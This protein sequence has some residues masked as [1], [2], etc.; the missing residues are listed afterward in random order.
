MNF[1]IRC[2]LA[3]IG[4][5]ANSAASCYWSDVNCYSNGSNFRFRNVFYIKRPEYFQKVL[6][7]L[8]NHYWFKLI[9]FVSVLLFCFLLSEDNS[10]LQGRVSPEI[11]DFLI[12][13]FGGLALM[14][15]RTKKETVVSVIVVIIV[16]TLMPPL[17]NTSY[18]LAK[19]HF[20][21][22]LKRCIC[23]LLVLFLLLW[24]SFCD[25]IIEF[26]NVQI[27]KCS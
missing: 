6:N 26:S 13:F 18:V 17:C 9:R 21:I 8:R 19:G 15:A 25:E 5:N 1:V 24:Q 27:C 12:A 14:L 3:S 23:I 4:L 22:F 11:R 16:T 20:L 10:E 7:E 2:F